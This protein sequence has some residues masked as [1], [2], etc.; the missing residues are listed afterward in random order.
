[1]NGII[2]C[3]LL[4]KKFKTVTAIDRLK[5]GI[6]E[7]KIIGL[8]GNN[9]AGKTTF[10]KIC[11]GYLKPTAGSVRVL[12]KSP[13]DD[14]SVLSDLIFIDEAMKYYEE[15]PLEDLLLTCRI[16]YKNW[17]TQFALKL[18][19]DCGLS[20]KSRYKNLSRG[21]KAQFNFIIGLASR[22]PVTL[23]D[24]PIVGMDAATRKE[25]YSILLRDYIENPRMFIISSHFLAEI[26]NI[27]EEIVLIDQGKLVLHDT[28]E[29]LQGYAVTLNG[30][31][32][33]VMEY[34]KDKQVLNLEQFGNTTI[35]AV[36]GASGSQPAAW[37]AQSGVHLS[38]VSVQDLCI[39]LTKKR[40]DSDFHDY[41]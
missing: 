6:S 5:F 29:K 19:S 40:K 23:M 3:D 8:I 31:R 32:E 39:Y 16:A 10:L 12:G 34:I 25:F 1:M 7:K 27:L 21:M 24:E 4:T 11:A 28:V 41:T 38:S 35:A 36:A 37:L 15:S 20:K 17:D 30:P 22:A 13:F 26:E 14:L 18:F 33:I 2:E 9:G